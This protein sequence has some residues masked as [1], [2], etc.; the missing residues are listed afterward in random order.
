MSS[1]GIRPT[2]CC[3]V[4]EGDVIGLHINEHQVVLGGEFLD[5]LDYRTAPRRPAQVHDHMIAADVGCHR[6]GRAGVIE[7]KPS[8]QRVAEGGHTAVDLAFD[9]AC[10]TVAALEH[11]QR[12]HCVG[13][14]THRQRCKVKAHVAIIH[15]QRQNITSL[16]DRG[17]EIGVLA[18]QAMPLI[19]GS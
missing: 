8:G 7:R 18:D 10:G 2:A 9:V 13:R 14:R 3:P 11:D 4:Q 6:P 12:C 16:E 17:C 19:P 1:T 5:C 15:E